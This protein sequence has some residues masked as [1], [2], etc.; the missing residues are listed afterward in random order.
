MLEYWNI[1]I[2]NNNMPIFSFLSPSGTLYNEQG[3]WCICPY[4]P[5]CRDILHREI[6]DRDD[7]M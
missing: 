7:V 2:L 4:I 1:G 5:S 6:D 3:G